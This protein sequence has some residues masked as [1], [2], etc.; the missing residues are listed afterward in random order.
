MAKLFGR[1]Y[2]KEQLLARTGDISQIAGV[3]MVEFTEGPQKGVAAAEFKTGSGLNFTVLLDRGMDISSADWCG[4]PL[5]WRSSAGEVHPHAY[6]PRGL[7]WIRSFYGGLVV[8]CG[9]TNIGNPCEDDG[10]E[11]GLHGRASNLMAFDVAHGG[12]WD[13]NEYVLF[14]EGSLRESRL[15]GENLLLRRRISTVMGENRLFID[16]IVTNEGS[17]TWP[18]LMLYHINPGFPVVDAGAQL[19][20]PSRKVTPR[21]ELSDKE[22][23][24]H[25]RFIQP[26]R[27]YEERVY[28]HRLAADRKGDTVAAVAN[29]KKG[30]A[31]LGVY[32]RFSRRQLPWLIEW[33]MMGERDYVVGIEPATNTVEGRAVERAAGRLAVLEPGDNR[34]YNLEIGVLAGA[35]QVNAIRREVRA[36]L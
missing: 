22:I 1:T 30:E 6:D 28:F 3:R 19:L 17:R 25:M 5:A 24:R 13:G 18:H 34:Y 10:E 12:Y 26:T 7:N 21:N 20:A 33:K 8:T 4:V 11:L 32:V 27:G 14:A 31:G 2:T 35:R 23:D 29:M 36:M 9:L 15:F 16:D